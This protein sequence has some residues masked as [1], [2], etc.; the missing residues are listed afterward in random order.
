MDQLME[1]QKIILFGFTYR[2]H[3]DCVVHTLVRVDLTGEVTCEV[4]LLV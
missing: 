4:D 2:L 1:F 3:S